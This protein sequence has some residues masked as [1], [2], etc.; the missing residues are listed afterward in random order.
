MDSEKIIL[1]KEIFRVLASETR[2]TILKK[3]AQRRMTISELSRELK[4]AKSTVHEHLALMTTAGLILP[5]PDEHQW[6][7]YEITHKGESLLLPENSMTIIILL[8]S[9]GFLFMAGSLAAF[10]IAWILRTPE[11]IQTPVHGAGYA[12]PATP[13]LYSIGIAILLLIAA[14]LVFIRSFRLRATINTEDKPAF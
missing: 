1:T 2:V 12:G 4:I 3:L 6:K 11:A 10:V 14:V 9:V 13:D 8:S 5:A 7:Y